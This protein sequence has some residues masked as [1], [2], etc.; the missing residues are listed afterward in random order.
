MWAPVAG[1]A[2]HAVIG[3]ELSDE[4]RGDQEEYGA[5]AERVVF[6]FLE[7]YPGYI[8]H[9]DL[10]KDS[11]YMN[12]Q[13]DFGINILNRWILAEVKGDSHLGK[14]GNVL[15]ELRRQIVSPEGL[16]RVDDGWSVR[17]RADCVLF[18]AS[19][20]KRIYWFDMTEYRRGFMRY[21]AAMNGQVPVHPCQLTRGRTAYNCYIPIE[22]C[23]HQVYELNGKRCR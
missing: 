9:R 21:T 19:S 12:R 10:R 17:S 23:E 22:Y 7:S 11:L 18:Y 3:P 20:V 5:E 14:T 8:E 13:V 2:R 6:R 16:V 15:Y 4:Y 1:V